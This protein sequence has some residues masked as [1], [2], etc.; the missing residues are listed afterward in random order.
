LTVSN[1]FGDINKWNNDKTRMDRVS[2]EDRRRKNYPFV[3]KY[4][5][6]FKQDLQNAP[7]ITSVPVYTNF[8]DVRSPLNIENKNLAR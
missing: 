6:E 7:T 2:K 8:I 5:G 1:D 3:S 4:W